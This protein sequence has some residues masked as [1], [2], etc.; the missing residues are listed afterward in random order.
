MVKTLGQVADYW[1]RDPQRALHMQSGSG[2]AYLD[3]WANAVKRM[4]ARPWTRSSARSQ[5]SPLRRSGMVEQSVLRLPQA[6][7]SPD[8]AM[9]EPAG[10]RRRG[11][12]PHTQQKAD[13]YVRQIANAIAPSNFVLTNPELL[14]ETLAS[15]AENLVRGMHMLAEDIAAGR[16]NL[17]IRQSGAKMF[18]VGRNLALTPAR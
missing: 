7:L 13:F 15:K 11:A 12:R 9:G 17:K 6:G 3:L 14:R 16:G 4:A 10:A 8:G 18:E 5:G 2:K 1:L